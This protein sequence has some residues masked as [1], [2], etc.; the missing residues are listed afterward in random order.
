VPD[1][2]RLSKTYDTK[3]LHLGVY[4]GPGCQARFDA[5][6]A[7]VMG[8]Q[9]R[10]M[11]IAPDQY[12][13]V[14]GETDLEVRL[15][16]AMPSDAGC[17]TC[18]DQARARFSIEG[19]GTRELLSRLVPI[20][21]D[22]LMFPVNAFAQ[23]GI[24]HVGGLLFRASEDRYELLVLRTYAASTWDVLLDAARPFGYEILK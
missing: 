17:V 15:R 16:S 3:L 7:S 2:L 19:E 13:V 11:R 18:L 4:P 20:D 6:V 8:P 22:P 14:D 5:A 9:H 23:T 12:W 1:L 10:I 21:L 24:H